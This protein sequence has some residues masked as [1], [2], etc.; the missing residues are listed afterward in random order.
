[1]ADHYEEK[2]P[3]SLRVT[4]FVYKD[5]RG[6]PQTGYIMSRLLHQNIKQIPGYLMKDNALI[7]IVSGSGLTRIGKSFLG[8]QIAY[9]S[10]WC[11]AGGEMN[12]DGT[13]K[14][15][16]TKP[17]IVRYFFDTTKLS[18]AIANETEDYQVYIL[19][20]GE[21]GAGSKSATNR[22]N[23]EFRDLVIR[24]ALKK[25]FLLIINP[26]FLTLSSQWACTHSDFLVNVYTRAG[27]KGYFTFYDRDRKTKLY[28][29]GKKLVGEARYGAAWPSFHG[30]FPNVFPGDF[31]K[32]NEDKKQ[33][34][35]ELTNITKKH[36]AAS[37]DMLVKK[38]Y[39]MSGLNHDELAVKLDMTPEAI[40]GAI[41]RANVRLREM[42]GGNPD[43][44]R[45]KN[46][47]ASGEV[48]NIQPESEIS[49]IR[50]EEERAVD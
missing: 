28:Y 10:A 23:K 1:M 22:R 24:S 18:E 39:E 7:G 36:S 20:E 19:D 15:L 49:P 3:H 50:L 8:F 46:G 31:A 37:K 11:I 33:S 40:H 2:L 29:W 34:L 43:G 25:Y 48:P 32:Y 5:W 38:I 35:L 12:E 21:A 27:V 45:T 16:P 9:Y 13:I 42:K 14:S 41:V 44:E 17:V 30:N 4:D 6:N 47:A 26:D